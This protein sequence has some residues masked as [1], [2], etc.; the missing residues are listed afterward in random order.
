MKNLILSL[1]QY[2]WV[3]LLMAIA[4]S[5]LLAHIG[6]PLIAILGGFIISMVVTR[7]LLKKYWNL[8]EEPKQWKKWAVATLTAIIGSQMGWVALLI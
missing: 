8:S 4:C 1:S 7:Y 5:A 6:I 2:L 3:L